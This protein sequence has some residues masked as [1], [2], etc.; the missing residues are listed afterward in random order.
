M[1][2]DFN[3][4]T[5]S[6]G[7]CG[8]YTSHHYLQCQSGDCV[9]ASRLLIDECGYRLALQSTFISTWRCSTMYSL[10]SGS[11][12]YKNI[13]DFT[14]NAL[15]YLILFLFFYVNILRIYLFR[16]WVSDHFFFNR[17]KVFLLAT[18]NLKACLSSLSTLVPLYGSPTL[19]C[20][21]HS[22][23]YIEY[24]K[25]VSNIFVFYSVV[26]S[27]AFLHLLGTDSKNCVRYFLTVVLTVYSILPLSITPTPTF[28]NHKIS[29]FLNILPL[30]DS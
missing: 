17:I 26:C 12:E 23:N 7:D 15:S 11:W 29:I 14:W 25:F 16:F 4:K 2:V 27:E 18:L 22:I 30:S 8:E 5:A 21:F 6:P 10:A 9:A 24:N 3:G 1:N 13:M 19:A 20:S 28:F